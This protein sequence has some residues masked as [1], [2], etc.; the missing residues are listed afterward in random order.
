M[1]QKLIDY[2]K[3]LKST[4]YDKNLPAPIVVPGIESIHKYIIEI[5]NKELGTSERFLGDNPKII[6]YHKMT[7]LGAIKDEVPWCASFVNY[8]LFQFW[9][10]YA[11]AS[12]NRNIKGV[13]IPIRKIYASTLEHMPKIDYFQDPLYSDALPTF[14]AAASSFENWGFSLSK[15]VPG[16]VAVLKRN[17]NKEVNRHVGF[18][19]SEGTSSGYITVL[20][21]NQMNSVCMSE[22]PIKDVVCYRGLV[23]EI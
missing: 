22:Y 23:P 15:P 5:A 14:S 12:L 8:V 20:G 18:Y 13:P 1:Y 11:S 16:C 4:Y 10:K 17:P 21:G 2:L 3:Y 19:F 9:L 6:A 7:T